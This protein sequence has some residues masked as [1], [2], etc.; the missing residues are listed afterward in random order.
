VLHAAPAPDSEELR[1]G[2]NRAVDTWMTAAASRL[3]SCNKRHQLFGPLFSNLSG[4]KVISSHPIVFMAFTIAILKRSRRPLTVSFGPSPRIN[5]LS[6]IRSWFSAS[7]MR[8]PLASNSPD[9]TALIT[10]CT[11]G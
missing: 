3:Q 7:R 5:T 1:K 8:A 4:K 2:L 6:L 11:I 10:D 9:S